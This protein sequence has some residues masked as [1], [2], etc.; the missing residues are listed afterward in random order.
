M[1]KAEYIEGPEAWTR[2]DALVGKVMSAPH[3]EVQRR[4]EAERA[5]SLQN[6]NRRGRKPKK[7]PASRAPAAQPHV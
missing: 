3:T 2:F 5:A 4:I 7:N 6:P 1:K